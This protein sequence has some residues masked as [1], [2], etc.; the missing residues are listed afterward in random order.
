MKKTQQY[1]NIKQTKNN[2]KPGLV[3]SYDRETKWA[4]S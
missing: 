3:T 4:Y 1:K 2:I